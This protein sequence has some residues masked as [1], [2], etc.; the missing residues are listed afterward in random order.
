MDDTRLE[1]LWSLAAAKEAPVYV[2]TGSTP[3]P[4]ARVTAPYTDPRY[5]EQ[6]VRWY[7]NTQFILGHVGYD[8]L[9]KEI[10]FLDACLDL[11]EANENVWLE[12]SALGSASSDPEGSNYAIVLRRIRARGLVDRLVYGSDGPQRP[13]F[14]EDYLQ[15]TLRAMEEANYTEDEAAAVLHGNAERLY[16]L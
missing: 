5:M 8:F 1:P 13:G 2:H 11:A 4:G 12:A 6:A 14:L 15:R 9:E 16:G 3:F 10:G 7:P